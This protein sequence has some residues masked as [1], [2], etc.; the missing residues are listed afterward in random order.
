[1]KKGRK[2]SKQKKEGKREL[3]DRWKEVEKGRK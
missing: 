1:M 3:K 2:G